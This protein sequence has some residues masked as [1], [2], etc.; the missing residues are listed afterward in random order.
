[1]PNCTVVGF[2]SHTKTFHGL[3]AVFTAPAIAPV[4]RFIVA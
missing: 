1:M 2:L 4:V 3:F